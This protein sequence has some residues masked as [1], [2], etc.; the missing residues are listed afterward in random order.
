MNAKTAFVDTNVWVYLYS[1]TYPAQKRAAFHAINDY[2]CFISTQVLN[3]FCNICIKN[4][5]KQSRI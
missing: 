5:E 2:E 3:E 1:D 4:L